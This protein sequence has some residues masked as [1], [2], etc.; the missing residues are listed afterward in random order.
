MEEKTAPPAAAPAAAGGL[1]DG[2]MVLTALVP[3]GWTCSRRQRMMTVKPEIT[4]RLARLKRR[5]EKRTKTPH[6]SLVTV[7]WRF[8]KS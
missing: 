5:N 1:A 6:N 8:H 2:S 3:S 4:V 7:G